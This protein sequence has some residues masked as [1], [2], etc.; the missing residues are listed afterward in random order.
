MDYIQTRGCVVSSSTDAPVRHLKIQNLPL[1]ASSSDLKR[2]F[3]DVDFIE[4]PKMLDWGA[5]V[6][7]VYEKD[8]RRCLL[9]HNSDFR[10]RSIT[11]K[12][13]NENVAPPDASSNVLRVDCF[14]Y[15][16]HTKQIKEFL[17]KNSPVFRIVVLTPSVI[18]N[19]SNGSVFVIYHDTETRDIAKDLLQGMKITDDKTGIERTLNTYVSDVMKM[20]NS[21]IR[22]LRRKGKSQQSLTAIDY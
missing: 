14:P 9:K 5:S 6:V 20:R 3:P 7:T 13:I 17:T 4:E 2:I 21:Q 16:W 10:G 15:H 12:M 19:E 8:V 11:V 22:A 1:P 18:G